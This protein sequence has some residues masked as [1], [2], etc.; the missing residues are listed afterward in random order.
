MKGKIFKNEN[1]EWLLK[2]EENVQI[3]P[4]SGRDFQGNEQYGW[5]EKI[6][7]FIPLKKDA[8]L[9]K[10]G[11]S[12]YFEKSTIYIEP[13][14]SIHCNRGYDKPVA[15]EIPPPKIYS[16]N[17]IEPMLK[18]LRIIADGREIDGYAWREANELLLTFDKKE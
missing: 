18:F 16:Q 17:D 7:P 5:V 12:H 15:M 10:E 1:G 2:Y 9:Y 11:Q 13:P 4:S 6:L 8:S 3:Y 14:E